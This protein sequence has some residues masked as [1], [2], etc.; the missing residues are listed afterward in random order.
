MRAP[1]RSARLLILTCAVL[2]L[3]P[4]VAAAQ[5]SP[6]S[7]L[8]S[9]TPAQTT[10][11]VAP[12]TN[13]TSTDPGGIDASMAFLL[14]GAGVV[15][16]GAIVFFIYRDARRRAPVAEGHT[17]HDERPVGSPHRKKRDA[18]ARA[19]RAKAARRQNR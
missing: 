11:T 14:F 3:A 2:A 16:L 4:A 6:F 15:L 18:R 7:P 1:M 17:A 13:T 9:A 5:S 19:K 12:A 10:T 8:P